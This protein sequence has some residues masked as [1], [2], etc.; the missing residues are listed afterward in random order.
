MSALITIYMR[1]AMGR[2][3][4]VGFMELRTET[5][6]V[7]IQEIEEIGQFWWERLRAIGGHGL[8]SRYVKRRDSGY[9]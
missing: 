1:F 7:L 4:K 9:R 8:G 2:K 6:A 5:A 3:T